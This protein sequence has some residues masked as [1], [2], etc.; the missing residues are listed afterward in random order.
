M[1]KHQHLHLALFTSFI[2]FLEKICNFL[3]NNFRLLRIFLLYIYFDRRLDLID[4]RQT[5]TSDDFLRLDRRV[6]RVVGVTVATKFVVRPDLVRR[7]FSII[8]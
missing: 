2:R 8:C 6:L 7:E 3:I 4:G 5:L 1:D